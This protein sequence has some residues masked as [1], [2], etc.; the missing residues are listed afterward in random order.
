VADR[1]PSGF[2]AAAAAGLDCVQIDLGGPNRGPDLLDA[3]ALAAVIGASRRF[4]LPISALAVNRL[5]D[6]GLTAPKGTSEASQSRHIILAAID[7]ADR[8]RIPWIVIPGFR[9]SL[10]RSHDDLARMAEVLRFVLD[11]V[12]GRAIALAYESALDADGTLGVLQAVGRQGVYVQFDTGNPAL[13]GHCAATIWPRVAHVAAP[14]VHIKDTPNGT[15][16]EY[17]PLG[18]GAAA[19]RHT[20]AT[21][22]RDPRPA[23]FTLEGNYHADPDSRLRRDLARLDMLIATFLLPARRA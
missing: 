10:I 20:F 11:A 13:H 18:E 21:F 6:L 19:V 22:A 3:S 23:A 9:R 16:D 5:N 15:I 17:V 8:L 2:E 14:D 12:Q 7:L 1:G 4:A